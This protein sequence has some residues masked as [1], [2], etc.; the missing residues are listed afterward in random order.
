MHN[1]TLYEERSEGWK[2]DNY[3][4]FKGHQILLAYQKIGTRSV[5]VTENK[6]IHAGE[7]LEAIVFFKLEKE[8]KSKTNGWKLNLYHFLL[9]ASHHFL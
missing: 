1:L 2:K 7:I 8:C 5:L 3:D 6:K 4:K 9:K